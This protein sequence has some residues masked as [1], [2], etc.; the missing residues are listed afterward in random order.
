MRR[1][2]QLTILLAVGLA[3]WLAVPRASADADD[4]TLQYYLKQSDIV[5]DA[6]VRSLDGPWYGEA[7]VANYGAVLDVHAYVKGTLSPAPAET[8]P[9]GEQPRPRV[10]IVRFEM[11]EQDCLPYLETGARLVLFLKSLPDGTFPAYQTSNFWFGVQPY[12]PWL[13]RRLTEIAGRAEAPR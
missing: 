2:T 13:V 4:D 11:D 12:G 10:T 1:L 7:G 3:A 9:P 6:T 8:L 5:V